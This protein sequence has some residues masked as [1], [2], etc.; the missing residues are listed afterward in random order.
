MPQETTQTPASERSTASRQAEEAVVRK[1][2]ADA[3]QQARTFKKAMTEI[4][5]QR[6]TI[7]DE[8]DKLRRA[9][10]QI[11]KADAQLGEEH[12]KLATQ[13]KELDALLVQLKGIVDGLDAPRS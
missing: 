4:E 5:G 3:R 9:M 12:A 7:G 13:Q 2:Y 6:K 1:A 11:K 10:D 8:L